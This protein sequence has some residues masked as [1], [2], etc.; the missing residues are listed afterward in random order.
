MRFAYSD[1]LWWLLIVSAS[2]VCA[3]FMV[4][5]QRRGLRA[6]SMADA[7][8]AAAISPARQWVKLTLRVVA[9]ILIG[10]AL[11]GPC[12]GE[13]ELP[14]VPAQGRDLLVVLD[15][16]RS[17]ATEDVTPSRLGRAK[18]D[19]KALA[20]ELEKRGGY[21]IG[22]IAFADR[23][24]LL[25]PLTTDF[26]HFY[27]ELGDTTLEALRVHQD[28]R[29]AQDGTQLGTALV[30]ALRAL[31]KPSAGDEPKGYC[32]V[33]LVSDGGDELDQQTQAVADEFAKRRVRI[34]TIGVGDVSKGS[35]IPIAGP[36]GR[37]QSLTY[38]GE[39]VHTKLEEA[40]LR[41]VARQTAAAYIAAGTKPLPVEQVV[42][43]LETEPTRELKATGQ[44]KDPIQRFEW[45]LVPAVLLLFVECLISTRRRL[46]VN[47]EQ[48]KPTR[49]PWLI[50]L[51][52]PPRR[53]R[54]QESGVRSQ[55][56]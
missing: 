9:L 34:F 11:L 20:M 33:L 15:V 6:F 1:N 5:R 7:A 13:Q 21:R 3:G 45:F 22:L 30:R 28:G 24:A 56:R 2:I 17:M 27:E 23:A 47:R 35:P 55:T 29:M 8:M 42:P 49:P 4:Y 14:P 46:P 26:R 40:V 53:I 32:D 36:G 51:I 25:C 19:L 44:I 12:W 43:L 39:V 10:I 41:D 38:Q 54:I 31:P 18:A 50:R 37:R 48:A 52:P 16:S